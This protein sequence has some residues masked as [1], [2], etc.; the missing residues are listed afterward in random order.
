MISNCSGVG[1]INYLGFSYKTKP[2]GN[3]EERYPCK[4][5]H[6]C[7]CEAQQQVLRVIKCCNCRNNTSLHCNN[8]SLHRQFLNSFNAI[9]YCS[10][11]FIWNLVNKLS[12]RTACSAILW[13]HMTIDI[14]SASISVSVSSIFLQLPLGTNLSALI[15]LLSDIGDRKRLLAVTRACVFIKFINLPKF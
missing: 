8:T 4:C 11:N 12:H 9:P 10:F 14:S 6:V 7:V 1:V 5:V 3:R 2:F 15:Q 13:M